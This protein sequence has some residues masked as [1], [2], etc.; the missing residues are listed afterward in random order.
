M[1][2]TCLPHVRRYVDLKRAL[3][4]A[5]LASQASLRSVPALRAL[6]LG[7]KDPFRT[8]K[9]IIV[10]SA[11]Q[12]I[13]PYFPNV[14]LLKHYFPN[15]LVLQAQIANDTPDRRTLAEV[16]FVVA[17]SSSEDSVV[18]VAN[19]PIKTL[20]AHS[21]GSAWCVLEIMPSRLE[22]TV[23][24]TCELRFTIMA[25]DLATGAPLSFSGE[26]G[27]GGRIYV[28]ELNDLE[29]RPKEFMF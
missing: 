28:E 14:T 24:L 10:R 19:V 11:S 22:E 21:A 12:P 2:T 26:G 4:E 25:V 27:G 3:T 7:A 8:S 5:Q 1:L 23:L 29:V 15:H 9:P 18:P 17:E 20:P 13:A 16:A 6:N